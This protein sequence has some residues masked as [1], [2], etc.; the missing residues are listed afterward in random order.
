LNSAESLLEAAISGL[1]IVMLSNMY[2]ADAILAGKLKMLLTDYVAVGTDVSAVYLP[3]RNLS[4]RFRA[5]IDFLVKLVPTPPRWELIT[6][7]AQKPVL[8]AIPED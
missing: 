5:F 1:G 3:N 6:H 2:T 7:A 4:P 8:A